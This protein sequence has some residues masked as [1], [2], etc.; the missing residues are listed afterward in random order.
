MKENTEFKERLSHLSKLIKS[1]KKLPSTLYT[2]I[3][4]KKGPKIDP[5]FSSRMVALENRDK[6]LESDPKHLNLLYSL[7]NTDNDDAKS[8][9]RAFSYFL[10]TRNPTEQNTRSQFTYQQIIDLLRLVFDNHASKKNKESESLLNSVKHFASSTGLLTSTTVNDFG[11]FIAN[12]YSWERMH[13]MQT[14]AITKIQ[15]KILDQIALEYQTLLLEALLELNG[16]T[17]LARTMAPSVPLQSEIKLLEELELA[18][19][20]A[21]ISDSLSK[22][23]IEYIGYT[24]ID[25]PE[26]LDDYKHPFPQIL[27]EQGLSPAEFFGE[28]FFA[29]FT[30]EEYRYHMRAI[31]TRLKRLVKMIPDEVLLINERYNT[32][33]EPEQRGSNT[34]HFDDMLEMYGIYDLRTQDFEEAFHYLIRLMDA[35]QKACNRNPTNRNP[36]HIRDLALLAG[37]KNERSVSNDLTNGD[38]LKKHENGK[39]AVI[40][41]SALSWLSHKNRRRKWKIPVAS[42]M[43]LDDITLEF[44]N[45]LKD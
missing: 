42:P 11:S 28:D 14:Y 8:F 24:L 25:A 9:W 12:R 7:L 6:K 13:N 26:K 39:G 41:D 27:D 10:I 38:V 31:S 35:H 29:P 36:L 44:I 17:T 33:P 1:Q 22:E 5:D 34:I 3:K 16:I 30:Q 18:T 32:M 19:S 20:A 4:A 2:P 23:D 45:S 37:L 43:F 21:T 15:P 40:Y